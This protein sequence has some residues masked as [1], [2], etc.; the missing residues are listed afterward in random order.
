MVDIEA[1]FHQVQISEKERSLGTCGGRMLIWEQ[2]INY[3]M[4]VHVSRGHHPLDVVTML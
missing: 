3:K 2:L 4:C 1:V